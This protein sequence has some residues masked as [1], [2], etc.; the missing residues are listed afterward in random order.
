MSRQLGKRRN[1]MGRLCLTLDV[2]YAL[3]GQNLD[4]LKEFLDNGIRRAIGDG[5]LA[6]YAEAEVE[7]YAADV[8]VVPES[9]TEA[10]IARLMARRIETG[11]LAV[12]DIPTRLA[13]YGLMNPNAFIEE[14]RERMQYR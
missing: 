12:K 9:L 4:D 2:T 7:V 13:R 11:E 3:N 6:D 1:N 10:T 5:L 14:M 8:R